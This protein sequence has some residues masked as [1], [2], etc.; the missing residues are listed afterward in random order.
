[1]GKIY[2]F[3]NQKGEKM[4]KYFIM[5]MILSAFSF[6]LAH[7]ASDLEISFE[8]ET[9]TLSVSYQHQVRDAETHYIEEIK[10]MLNGEEIIQQKL[11]KQAETAGGKLSYIIIDAQAEDEIEVISKCNKFGNKKAKLEI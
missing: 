2:L 7:P 8:E 5:I 1:M 11:G 4:K 6:L 9:A 3:P 10:V